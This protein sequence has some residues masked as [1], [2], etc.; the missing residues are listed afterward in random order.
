MLGAV[1]PVLLIYFAFIFVPEFFS[2]SGIKR[3]AVPAHK[4]ANM[5]G[6]VSCQ[7]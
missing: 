3:A 2:A 1:L 5:G 7:S 4:R 6:T